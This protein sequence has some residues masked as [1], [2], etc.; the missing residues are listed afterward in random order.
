MK[1]LHNISSVM[2]SVKGADNLWAV[3]LPHLKVVLVGWNK[4]TLLFSEPFCKKRVKSSS[5]LL[6]DPRSFMPK[7]LQ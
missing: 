3:V 2:R 5:S 4:V 6:K 7:A 1:F